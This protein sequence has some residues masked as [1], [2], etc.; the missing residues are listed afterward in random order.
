MSSI[1]ICTCSQSSRWREGLKPKMKRRK[2]HSRSCSYQ[3]SHCESFQ[4]SIF[5]RFLCQSQ[6]F[7]REAATGSRLW[8]S[9]MSTKGGYCSFSFRGESDALY[10]KASLYFHQLVCGPFVSRQVICVELARNAWVRRPED[11]DS[12]VQPLHFSS[13]GLDER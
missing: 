5:S 7:S 4:T 3:C 11:F 13:L 6:G 1:W 2:S 12:G 8:K 10:W 9:H